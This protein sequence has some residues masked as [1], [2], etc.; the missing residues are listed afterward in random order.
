MRGFLAPLVAVA[1]VLLAG[2]ALGVDVGGR[3]DLLEKGRR[4]LEVQYAV[5][6]YTPDG[7]AKVKPLAEPLEVVTVR[8]EFNPRSVAVP[9]GSTVRFPNQDPILHNVFSL[10]GANKFDLG[11]VP[12]GS[13][14]ET[15]LRHPGPVQVFC[16]VH[17]A[18]VANVLVLDTPYYAYPD[19]QG[20]F[21]LS[22][23]PA[24]EGT[25]SVWHERAEPVTRRLVTTAPANPLIVEVQASKARVPQHRNKL[26][27]PYSRRKDYG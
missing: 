22:N 14:G 3:V 8:K 21:V 26:G 6:T 1:G 5:V 12:K 24:G 25:L 17:H 13:A 23:L 7:G 9:V 19:R 27:Q 2:A 20:A 18:M 10:S 11:L 16:N 4:S 15:V